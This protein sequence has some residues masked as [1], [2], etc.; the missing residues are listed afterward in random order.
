MFRFLLSFFCLLPPALSIH[1]QSTSFS[2]D[3]LT[4]DDGLSYSTVHDILQ[5]DL[6][7]I[8]IGT[9]FGLNRFDGY[10]FKTFLPN[11]KDP[12]AIK[13]QSI[14]CLHLDALGNIWI[15]HLNGGVSEIA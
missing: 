7:M 8:W 5:D 11:P 15:G 6:G 9:R 1:A 13:S 3:H 2:F 12:Y 14:F 10:E 4:V